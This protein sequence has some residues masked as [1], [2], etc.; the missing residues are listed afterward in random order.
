MRFLKHLFAALSL[1]LIAGTAGASLSNPQEG[2]DYKMLAKPQPT[3]AGKKVE[4]IEFFGYFCP[5]CH[6]LDPMLADWVKKQGDKIVFKRIHVLFHP[7]MLPVQQL[8]VTLESMGKTEELHK[9]IFD[10]M[11]K[12]RLRLDSEAAVIAFVTQNG[13]DKQK[14]LDAY[15]SFSV[16]SKMRQ[17]PK[18]QE[19]YGIDSVPQIIIDGR[20]VATPELAR[21]S[22]GADKSEANLHAG[23]MQIMDALVDRISKEKAA[24][25]AK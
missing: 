5:H 9:K 7:S 1:T 18:I 16:Q 20:I 25:K 23:L 3:E 13:I 10:A 6:A 14:F 4:V 15:N 11:H 12:Q 17:L 24:G 22:I 8:Y 19:A 2:V 21:A